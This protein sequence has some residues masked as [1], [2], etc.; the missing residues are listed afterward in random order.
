MD[1]VQTIRSR[2]LI[3]LRRFTWFL[4]VLTVGAF[5]TAPG[6]AAAA[7]TAQAGATGNTARCAPG[8]VDSGT[9]D[10]CVR[11]ATSTEE[12]GAGTMLPFT[13]L[14]LGLLA[15]GGCVLWALGFG[16]HLLTRG[17]RTT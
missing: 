6:I 3:S 2:R 9:D 4:I 16:V 1:V 8:F 10:G 12:A 7:D 17:P 15:A 13:G 5:A 14:D 11:L